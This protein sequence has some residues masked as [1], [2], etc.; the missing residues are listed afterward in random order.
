MKST[1]QEYK[2][3]TIFYQNFSGQFYNSAAVIAE[4]NEVQEVVVNQPLHSLLVL[5]DLRD[6]QVGGD[7]LSAMNAASTRTKDHVRK[8]AVL[9][10]TGVKRTLGDML[11]RL[12]GQPLMYFDNETDAR[13][14]LVQE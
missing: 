6:T 13:E 12:T 9:G 2:G 14:W 3:K 10:V 7:V 8:T 11:S 1:W 5:T 4:L